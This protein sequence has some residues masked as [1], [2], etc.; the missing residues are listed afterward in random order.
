P[1][2]SSPNLS[3]ALES[4]PDGAGIHPA[5][6]SAALASGYVSPRGKTGDTA[7]ARMPPM[8]MP[9]VSVACIGCW[10]QEQAAPPVLN[11]GDYSIGWRMVV[12]HSLGNALGTCRQEP[13]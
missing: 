13:G 6:T 1:Q 4:A 9:I 5:R 11:V 3:H 10:R 2:T 7:P 8:R 12:L